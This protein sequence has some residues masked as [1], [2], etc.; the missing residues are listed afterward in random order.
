MRGR[1]AHTVAF[2]VSAPMN[3]TIYGP[4]AVCNRMN[5]RYP[6]PTGPRP[7]STRRAKR[8][9]RGH[10]VPPSTRSAGANPRLVAGSA[11][12]ENSAKPRFTFGS[13]SAEFVGKPLPIGRER[14]GSGIYAKALPG[15]RRAVRKDMTLVRA[16]ASANDL[17]SDHA[18]A[19]IS[20]APEMILT[21]RRGEAR[22][23]GAAFELCA[24]LEQRQSA[25]AAGIQ[26][27]A[28]LMEEDAAERGLFA[29]FE[30]QAPLL[31]TEVCRKLPHLVLC[32]RCQ[33]KSHFDVRHRLTPRRPITG[34]SHRLAAKSGRG[35]PDLRRRSFSHDTDG[36][37]LAPSFRSVSAQ[38]C[39][40]DPCLPP[41]PRPP[42]ARRR[43][44]QNAMKINVS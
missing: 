11:V 20:N 16:A 5:Y 38:R 36:A 14:E 30:Q 32:G 4:A 37:S 8:P 41:A 26:P 13:A 40:G 7:I 42:W 10:E 39:N 21:D 22:P 29:V 2:V 18:V 27:L 43:R 19:G 44:G 31:L 35:R 34:P 17:R 23:A 6:C 25:E 33:I 3:S 28:F 9:D 12:S 1:S 15:R 24:G